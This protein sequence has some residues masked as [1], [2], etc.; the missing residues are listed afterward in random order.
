VSIQ[1]DAVPEKRF[2]GRIKSM[3]GTASS[4]V[5]SGDPAK[6]F[7]VVFSIDMRQLLTDLGVKPQD[8]QRIM[9]TAERNAKRAPVSS[10]S[11]SSLF[12]Q[13]GAEMPGPPMPGEQMAASPQSSPEGEERG[14]RSRGER[15]MSDED[16]KKLRAALGGKDIEKMSPEERKK[17]FA[18]A[19]SGG[20][21]KGEGGRAPSGLELLKLSSMANPQFSDADREKAQLPPPPE[22]DSQ[23]EVLLRPGL[24]ADVEITVEKI[25]NALHVP[26]QAV[27]EKEGRSIVYVQKDGRFEERPVKLSK[28]SES[29]MILA[30]GVQPGEIVALSD[31]YAKAGKKGEDKKKGAGGGNPMGSMPG[32]GSD[33]GGGRRGGK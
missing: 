19:R 13:G 11:S 7:D 3:S 30:G 12:Q 26:A 25:P 9:A 29:M 15:K 16:R 27:F 18:S 5:F 22:E 4:N 8:V 2:R 24:L 23:L 20:G 28:R 17:A 33:S 1:L 21:Q 32:G 31:P 14:G 6:K 10:Y